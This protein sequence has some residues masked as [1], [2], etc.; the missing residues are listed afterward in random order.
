MHSRLLNGNLIERPRLRR[1]APAGLV[2]LLLTP[3]AALATD[4][5]W[6]A[7]ICPNDFW[8]TTT[9]W[10]PQGIPGGTTNT[11]AIG[12]SFDS[13]RVNVFA[14]T[15][16]GTLTLDAFTGASATRVKSGTSILTVGTNTSAG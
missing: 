14:A 5:K 2:V 15:T 16:I 13:A 3:P 10:S 1:C 6:D 8:D 4:Y 11:A 7:G 12:P 9:C